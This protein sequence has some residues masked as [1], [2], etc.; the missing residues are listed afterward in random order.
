MRLDDLIIEARG[1]QSGTA[2]HKA[3]AWEAYQQRPNDG[4]DYERWS[5]AYELNQTRASS[6]RAAEIDYQQE[7]GWGTVQ[8]ASLYPIIEGQP[9]ARKLDIVDRD[10]LRAVE[11]KTGY[12]SATVDNLWELERDKALVAAG[13]DIEWAFLDTKPSQ[14]LI[15]ALQG[16]GIR[17]VIKPGN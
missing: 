16:A 11:V 6:A 2:E 9:V 8:G 17:V 14:P 12:Q 15:D 1:Y 7:I 5:T 13:W 4:W 3:A 10:S